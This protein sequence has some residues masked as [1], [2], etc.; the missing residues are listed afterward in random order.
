G[1][2]N[3]CQ[4]HNILVR[5]YVQINTNAGQALFIDHISCLPRIVSQV[6]TKRLI[7]VPYPENVRNRSGSEP[8]PV[9]VKRLQDF[10]RVQGTGYSLPYFYI[11][12][13][14][15]RRIHAKIVS[16]QTFNRNNP[17]APFFIIPESGECRSRKGNDIEIAYLKFSYRCYIL[18]YD[19]VNKA[20]HFGGAAKIIFPSLK[21]KL[22]VGHPR[23]QYKRTGADD[24]AVTP[25]LFCMY[26]ISRGG[27]QHAEER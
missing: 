2:N 27:C 11:V 17:A 8:A 14:W 25:D 19:P 22:P 9:F 7:R 15:S 18:P 24:P 1:L 5:R 4:I 23:F 6:F 3:F 20:F 21:D 26:D 10:S 12:E 13:G 16:I